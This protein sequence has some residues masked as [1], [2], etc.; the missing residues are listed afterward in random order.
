M[1]E[2]NEMKMSGPNDMHSFN[3]KNQFGIKIEKKRIKKEHFQFQKK[4][5]A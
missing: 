4:K 1:K 3:L 2:K 5:M